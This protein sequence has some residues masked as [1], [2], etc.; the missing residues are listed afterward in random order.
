MTIRKE[1]DEVGQRKV[2]NRDALGRF[3]P[4][5]IKPLSINVKPITER[6]VM[7]EKECCCF[8]F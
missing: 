1:T 4:K 6:N 2:F 8:Y 3:A 7:E 5:A